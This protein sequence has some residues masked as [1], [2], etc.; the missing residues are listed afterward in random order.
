MARTRR[1][2][3]LAEQAPPH[4]GAQFVGGAV[5]RHLPKGPLC[6]AGRAKSQTQELVG[7]RDVADRRVQSHP[8]AVLDPARHCVASDGTGESQPGG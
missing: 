6:G 7:R 3:N 2:L 4:H 5:S 1:Y 8:V